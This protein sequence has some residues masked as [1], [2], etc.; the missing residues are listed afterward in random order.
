MAKR[1]KLILEEPDTGGQQ[2]PRHGDAPSHY[3]DGA[4]VGA[5]LRAARVRHGLE[6][7][8]VSKALRI[9]VVH[10]Q[11]MEEGRLEDL[12]GSTYAV[13]FVRGY[14]EYLGLDP[15]DVI[16][17]FREGAASL[18]KRSELNFPTAVPESRVPTG[19]ILLIS[20][21]LAATAYGGWYYLTMHSRS[22]IEFVAE[23]PRQLSDLIG[24]GSGDEARSAL[25]DEPEAPSPADAVAMQLGEAPERRPFADAEAPDEAAA[26]GSAGPGGDTE[27]RFGSTPSLADDDR[28]QG[29]SMV[30]AAPAEADLPAREATTGTEI[31]TSASDSPPSGRSL[32]DD[33]S[34]DRVRPAG[35][36]TEVANG[37]ADVAEAVEEAVEEVATLH[38]VPP[39]PDPSEGAAAGPA[40]VFGE[41]NV[42]ARIVIRAIDESWVQVREEGGELVLTRVLRPGDTYRVPNRPGLTLLTGNAG[43]LEIFVD[44]RLA[45]PIGPR[46]AIRRDVALDVDRLLGA[47]AV[48]N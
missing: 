13:G 39:A 38:A 36:A 35:E 26:E 15:D 23:V 7:R 4:A 37:E 9:R 6:L 33:A 12:P 31:A 24:T 47:T 46:G 17:R 29:G 19:A 5:M 28:A 45:P 10:L 44:G 48:G 40:Q 42:D 11:A 1:E 21:V 41:A 32:A 2:E 30:P 22:G 16:S 34:T 27:N 14:A 20:A 25:S 8:D 18:G 3:S 43:A